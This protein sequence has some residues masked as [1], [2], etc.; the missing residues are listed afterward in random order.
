MR[1]NKI[2]FFTG[3]AAALLM[4]WAAIAILGVE[5]TQALEQP[6][7]EKAAL[8]ACE[9]RLC[10]IVV[11]KQPAGEDLVC[12]LS[13]TW[14]QSKIK[15]GIEK[16]RLSWAFGD[17][18]CSVDLSAKRDLIL[19][20]VTKP[21]HALELPPHQVKCEIERD[22]EITPINITLAPRIAFK[23]GK[24]EKAWLNLKSIE[25]PAVV[26]GAIWTAAQIED[27]FGLFHS[28]MISE[29][30]EF[31]EKKCPKALAGK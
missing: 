23:N 31:V 15:D 28:D 10:E 29:I 17:A 21:E 3:F 2:G 8:K 14:T 26:K 22:K 19:G 25:G 24:A 13:K 5:P 11:M 30:N 18:R 6:A 1:D 27:N 9:Q 16:R 20:A 4:G 12:P 7:D